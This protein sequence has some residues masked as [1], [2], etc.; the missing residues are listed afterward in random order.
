M[1]ISV[2]TIVRNDCTHI[3]ETLNS[4]LEQQGTEFELE[5]V[6]IDGASDDGTAEIVGKYA[7][8]LAFFVSEKDS[9]IYNAMNKGIAHCTGDVIGMINSGDRYLPGAL[10]LVAKSFAD[11]GKLD[12]IFWGDVV[13]QHLG[14]VKGF[15]ENNRYRGAFAPHPSMFVPRNIYETIGC[16]DESFRL[17]GDYEFMYRAVN[18]KNI[19]PLYVAQP[20][21]F[22]LED[23]LSDR[24]VY[25]CL[26]DELTV[27]LRYG[28][29]PVTAR[30]IFLLKVIKNSPRILKSLFR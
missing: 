10:A 26:K 22:Y 12:R 1:K 27:K 30:L 20:V 8:K 14:L 24:Y 16:Y 5:Y 25:R 6:V 18:V 9:G 21:A 15:R 2:V 11:Y 28:Q 3:E 29:N 17:L 7:E 23:G 19:L 4:V 13:Y